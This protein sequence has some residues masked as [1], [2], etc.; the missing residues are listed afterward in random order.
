MEDQAVKVIGDIGQGQ[1]S[2]GA[3]DPDGADK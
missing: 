3:S 2:L 1:L